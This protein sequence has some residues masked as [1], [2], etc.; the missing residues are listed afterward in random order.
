MI[1]CGSMKNK[2]EELRMIPKKNY[3]KISTIFVV[4]ILIVVVAFVF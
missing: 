4:T 2:K 1:G 3:A